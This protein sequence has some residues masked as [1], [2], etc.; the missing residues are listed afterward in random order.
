VVAGV[1]EADIVQLLGQAR[2]E[3]GKADAAG[4]KVVLSM[5]EKGAIKGGEDI[6]DKTVA[7]G[8]G[9]IAM[10]GWALKTAPRP[11]R[12]VDP[13]HQS[14]LQDIGNR[15]KFATD[16]ANFADAQGKPLDF[17]PPKTMD[18]RDH[19]VPG[20]YGNTHAEQQVYTLSGARAI[21]VTRPVCSLCQAHFDQVA[22]SIK[23]VIVV[24]APGQAFVFLPDGTHQI[25]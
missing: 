21:G 18:P 15:G 20:Q 8:G 6:K 11:G 12:T 25:R 16:T 10:S 2:A 24:A 22:K 7:S 4:L 9:A 17:N 1:S 5:Q 14:E 3:I 23:Q 13:A 19:G